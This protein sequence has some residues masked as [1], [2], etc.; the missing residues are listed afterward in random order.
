MKRLIC[1]MALLCLSLTLFSQSNV[2]YVRDSIR[3][4]NY[5]LKL[6][7]F[8]RW[9][10]KV[11]YS[12]ND[13]LFYVDK[14]GA[15]HFV[16][17]IG[18]AAVDLSRYYTQVQT[19]S[20]MNAGKFILNQ[21]DS[22]QNAN[23]WF[24]F[25]Q[26]RNL[27]IIQSS[28]NGAD[29]DMVLEN[30]DANGDAHIKLVKSPGNLSR[31]YETFREKDSNHVWNVGLLK[32][33]TGTNM[34]FQIG[35]KTGFPINNYEATQFNLFPNGFLGLGK[36]NPAYNLDVAGQANFDGG[37]LVPV[38]SSGDSSK[39]VANTAWVKQR[40]AGLSTGSVDLSNYYTKPQADAAFA[41]TSHTHTFSSLTSK[42]STLAGYGITD[43]VQ[44]VT[45]KGL[46]TEDY[47]T[48]E[49]TKLAGI[50]TGAT[51][52]SPDATLLNRA[53]H[54]GTQAATTITQD[55]TH[56]FATDTEKNTWN[57]SYTSVTGINDST[58]TLNRI[59]GTKD[60]IVIAG[61]T[62][63]LSAYELI[64]HAA[65][66][67]HPLENQRLSTTN[68]PTF[69]GLTSN[70]IIKLI[71]QA[72]T[73]SAPAVGTQN[74]YADS[75]GTFTIQGS[76]SFALSL[77]KAR[78]TA[79]HR[80]F[81]QNKDYTPAD[82]ADV[83]AK[84]AT[85]VSGTNIKSINGTSLLGSG[86][87]TIGGGNG[88]FLGS[89][90]TTGRDTITA[91]ATGSQVFNTTNGWYEYFDAFWGWMPMGITAEWKKQFGAEYFNDFG[92][93]SGINDGTL[94]GVTVGTGAAI[95]GNG[96]PA[97]N[98]PGNLLAQTGTTN[99]GTAGVRTDFNSN[100]YYFLGGGLTVW[101]TAINLTTLSNSTDRYQATAGFT[102]ASVAAL[103]NAIC[104]AYDEGGTMT[105][106][107]ASANFQ[108]ITAGSSTRTFTDTGIPVVAGT[109]YKLRIEINAAGTQIKFYINGTLVATHTTN[110]TTLP[111]P[112]S[113]S[114]L[115]SVG[116]T[117]RT[118]G[119]DYIS[120][121]EKFTTA[122]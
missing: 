80:V 94:S 103:A 99:V 11:N 62:P 8:N 42:P 75:T 64:T 122:R 12:R 65:A 7:T 100:A 29:A 84:Q 61:T 10:V 19:D 114:I 85:L 68:S 111:L 16:S 106:G 71:G 41:I 36:L 39:T 113:V 112:M 31:A 18:A 73:P 56:R 66:T 22:E 57:G 70:G 28:G 6:S 3:I 107:S 69:A 46:S 110:I 86:N 27:H 2:Y 38:A 51:A 52:N 79:N 44:Q 13:S 26:L 105:G 40:I 92:S 90:P 115:K 54:T 81:F 116:T 37:A 15:E 23:A 45:G 24:K 53:N 25:L 34:P 60:T 117:N 43:A 91:P 74:V 77:S 76:N 93:A 9:D 95:N 118:M 30:D 72:G 59:N 58:F 1:L 33:T 78:L 101:E 108:T 4:G 20:L 120:F 47:T 87:I 32:G 119:I 102:P 89:Y 104:F 97:V 50:A 48:A 121:K 83:A 63:D 55:A 109:W 35:Y 49:K 17:K 98:R 14:S 21:L 96:V 88:L 82:S 67:Y 5:W